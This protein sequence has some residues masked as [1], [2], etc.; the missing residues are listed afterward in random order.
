LANRLGQSPNGSTH[1]S[2]QPVHGHSTPGDGRDRHTDADH[3]ND[4]LNRRKRYEYDN[5][6]IT[7]R[8]MGSMAGAD[9]QI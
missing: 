1:A 8:G 6:R 2:R 9:K 5:E 4:C 3:A 7:K